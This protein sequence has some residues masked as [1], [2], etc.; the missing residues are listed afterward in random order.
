MVYYAFSRKGYR[1][2]SS[3]ESLYHPMSASAALFASNFKYHS[4]IDVPSFVFLKSVVD[5]GRKGKWPA[6]K[7]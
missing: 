3:F 6:N 5:F 7:M 1:I 2:I 4:C